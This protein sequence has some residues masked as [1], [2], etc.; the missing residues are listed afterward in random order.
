MPLRQGAEARA[1]SREG[2]DRGQ[3]EAK[4]VDANTVR[5]RALRLAEE[6]ADLAAA[7]AAPA[8]PA[9]KKAKASTAKSIPVE[10]LNASN[11]E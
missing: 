3:S 11:D 6:A 1:G 2:A 8:A 10:A 9:K 4:R 7:A 5:L